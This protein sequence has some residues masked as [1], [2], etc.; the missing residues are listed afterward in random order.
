V[1]FVFFVV[2][3]FIRVHPCVAAGDL[4]PKNLCGLCVSVVKITAL[5][6]AKQLK[7]LR[8]LIGRTG[9]GRSRLF[10]GILRRPYNK[11]LGHRFLSVEELVGNTDSLTYSDTVWLEFWVRLGQSTPVLY[12]SRVPL[13]DNRERFSW[14]LDF[15]V[16]VRRPRLSHACLGFPGFVPLGNRIHEL[17]GHRFFGVKEVF[18]Y[19]DSSADGDTVWVE[20]GVRLSQIIPVFNVSRIPFRNH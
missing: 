18:G 12:F 4:C 17:L 20:L 10:F 9:G 14:V 8:F 3:S 5:F 7:H 16:V 13:G 15:V 11:A 1:S 19:E 2:L 6:R